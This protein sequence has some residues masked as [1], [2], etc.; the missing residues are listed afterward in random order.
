MLR[1][2]VVAPEYEAKGTELFL[3]SS[4]IDPLKLRQ[5]LL[6]WDRID[7]PTNN[8]I[9]CTSNDIDYLESLNLLQRTKYNCSCNGIINM[10]ELFLNAQIQALNNNNLNKNERWT[11]GQGNL[12][13]LL[14]KDEV[15]RKNTLILDLY[16]SLPIPATDVPLDDIINFKEKRRD[17]LMEFRNSMDKIYLSIINS[18][19][20]DISKSVAIKDLEKKIIAI[21]KV[22]NESKIKKL[23]GSVKVN[24]DINSLIMGGAGYIIGK[25]T[26][27]SIMLASLG[28]AASSIKLRI[29][30]QLIPKHIPDNLSDFAYLYYSQKEL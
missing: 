21:N 8:I 22:M 5:Y 6:Y 3:K 15:E 7:F 27:N 18:G 23:L 16:N 13:L 20:I 2:I 12:N 1:G 25:E 9:H 14:P 28:L 19:D 24:I 11:L 4:D 26:G 10:E 29:D 17:E 30:K